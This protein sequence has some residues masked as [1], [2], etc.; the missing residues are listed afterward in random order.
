MNNLSGGA[1]SNQLAIEIIC[2]SRLRL[3]DIIIL[4]KSL[5]YLQ[6]YSVEKTSMALGLG[7][8]NVIKVP[9]DDQGKMRSNELG[10][11]LKKKNFP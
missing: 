11:Y 1:F 10:D 5:W 7:N 3:E 8:D 2:F 6:G 9:C 4:T